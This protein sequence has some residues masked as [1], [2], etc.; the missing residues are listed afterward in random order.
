MKVPGFSFEE[1]YPD[2][3]VDLDHDL[4]IIVEC[5]EQLKGRTE[6]DITDKVVV[7]EAPEL[8]APK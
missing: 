4:S 3:E 5:L 2:V 1:I 7:V 8:E 6:K